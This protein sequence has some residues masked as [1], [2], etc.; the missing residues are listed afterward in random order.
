MSYDAALGDC[1]VNQRRNVA[2]IFKRSEIFGICYQSKL[3]T[4]IWIFDLHKFVK[5][6]NEWCNLRSF[7]DSPACILWMKY[8]FSIFDNWIMINKNSTMA[9]HNIEKYL[10]VIDEYPI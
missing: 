10:K 8:L 7:T 5:V 6:I 9:T 1:T 4:K 3:N 2:K